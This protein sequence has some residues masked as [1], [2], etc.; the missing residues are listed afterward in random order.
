MK[1]RKKKGFTLL[2]IIAAVSLIVIISSVAI[3]MYMNIVDKQK[4]N[5]DLAVALQLEQQAKTYYIENKDT[6]KTKLKNYIEEIYGTMPKSKYNG[7][8]FTVEFDTAKKVTVSAGGKT[9]IDKGETKELNNDKN[10]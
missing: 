9:F 6:D 5:T 7:K 3:P 1:I 8:E 10:N 2:E 4:Y